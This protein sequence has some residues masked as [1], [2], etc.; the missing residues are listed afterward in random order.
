MGKQSKG[1]VKSRKPLDRDL[2]K[3]VA[4][5]T[6][7]LNHV[8]KVFLTPGT[9]LYESFI[10]I[11]YFTMPVMCYFLVEGFRYTRSKVNYGMRLLIFAALSELPFCM[12]FSGASGEGEA[13]TF[14]GMNMIF[15]LALCYY[16]VWAL[17]A[18]QSTFLKILAVFAACF[19]STFSDWGLIAPMFTLLFQ[20]A[21]KDAEKIKGAFV[22]ATLLLGLYRFL[23]VYTVWSEADSIVYALKNMLG[24][25]LAGLVIVFGYNGRRMEKGRNFSKWFF[26]VYYPLHLAILGALRM[27][28]LG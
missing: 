25:A 9:A 12:A 20:W 11:G 17:S 19:I 18:L 16:M 22:A 15:T 5:V 6:M 1:P 2:I 10:Y 28:V 23:G 7:T 24:P 3:Y 14:C 21:G 13:L 4:I 27:W 8:A 26:Y